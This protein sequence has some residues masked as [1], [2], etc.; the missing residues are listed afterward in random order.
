MIKVF[1]SWSNDLTRFVA[2]QFYQR[3]RTVLG[4]KAEPF[5]SSHMVGGDRSFNKMLDALRISDYGLVF[6]SRDELNPPWVV[7][8]AGAVECNR[9]CSTVIPVT[10]G[11]SPGQTEPPLRPL[12]QA[13]SIFDE[14]SIRQIFSV[15]CQKAKGDSVQ[16]EDG[17]SEWFSALKQGTQ[18]L[19]IGSLSS[20]AGWELV[21]ATK[22]A[23]GTDKSPFQASDAFRLASQRLVFVG[24]N[25]WSL[26][27][28]EPVASSWFW[29]ETLKFLKGTRE[30]DEGVRVDPHTRKVDILVIDPNEPYLKE[31]WGRSIGDERGF[32]E[33]LWICVSALGVLKQLTQN[34]RVGEDVR[35][36]LAKFIPLS[37]TFIDPD[38]PD[39]G[40]LFLRPFTR[41]DRPHDRP[42][43]LVTRQSNP[44]AFDFYWTRHDTDFTGRLHATELQV[45]DGRQDEG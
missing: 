43:V 20:G 24:Q 23:E 19:L 21:K 39:R 27:G 37:A 9:K 34:E 14:N 18:K 41:G 44:R 42:I 40:M 28:K 2:E 35:I 12:R 45:T 10:V 5:L 25:L 16:V 36:K 30:A 13:V 3:L 29:T 15:I 33:H 4:G 17:F 11:F 6:L 26:V 1:L 8:E 32:Q 38:D 7:F 31:A 22:L